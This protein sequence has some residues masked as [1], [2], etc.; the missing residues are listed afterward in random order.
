MVLAEYLEL[1]FLK[2]LPAIV[3]INHLYFPWLWYT[4]P[5]SRSQPLCSSLPKYLCEFPESHCIFNN[6]SN[7][8][9]MNSQPNNAVSCLCTSIFLGPCSTRWHRH[10]SARHW[11]VRPFLKLLSKALP[12]RFWSV[13]CSW[14]VCQ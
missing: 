5:N 14:V 11:E 13:P 1:E 10:S 3:L 7:S 2:D 4:T 9:N 8:A 12:L 6:K